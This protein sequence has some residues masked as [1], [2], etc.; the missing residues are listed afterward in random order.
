[1]PQPTASAGGEVRADQQNQVLPL[2]AGDEQHH[3]F[4]RQDQRELQAG[5][6]GW[7]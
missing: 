7:K 4:S 3:A 1:M 6:S 5:V 2:L